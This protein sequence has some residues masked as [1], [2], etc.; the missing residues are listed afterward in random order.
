MTT[1]TGRCRRHH[2]QTCQGPTSHGLCTRHRATWEA[3]QA[4]WK[5]RADRREPVDT[6]PQPP[7]VCYLHTNNNT[8]PDE[9]RALAGWYF[10]HTACRL[11]DGPHDSE[12]AAHTANQGHQCDRPAPGLMPFKKPKALGHWTPEED[13]ILR[14]SP[15]IADSVKKIPYRSAKA[16][17]QHRQRLGIGGYVD[18]WTHEQDAA[19]KFLTN[20]EA[21]AQFGRTYSAVVNRRFQLGLKSPV[22][23]IAS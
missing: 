3:M 14:D 23:R 17:E 2:Q 13:A 21:V 19:L 11:T 16:V 6:I 8:A 22:R 15:T 7:H 5:Q 9:Y 10:N 12:D 20:G 18:P 4:D 1:M